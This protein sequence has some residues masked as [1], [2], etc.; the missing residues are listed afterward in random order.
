MGELDVKDRSP[1]TSWIMR[2]TAIKGRHV[3]DRIHSS[4]IKTNYSSINT[5]TELISTHITFSISMER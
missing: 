2:E 1:Q 3:M 4:Y 5:V